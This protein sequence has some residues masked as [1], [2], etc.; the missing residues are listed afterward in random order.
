MTTGGDIAGIEVLRRGAENGTDAPPLLFLHGAF[1]GAWCWDEH[2]MP[3][4][5]DR[6]YDTMAFSFRGHGRS[7]GHAVL[8]GL[9]IDDYVTDLRR[10]VARFRR[11]PVLVGHS[12]GGYVAM[13][14]LQQGGEAAGLVLMASVP[15][16]GLWGPCAWLWMTR[17]VLLW[18]IGALQAVGNHGATVDMAN[19]ALFNGPNGRDLARRYVPRMGNESLRACY[20]MYAPTV[21]GSALNLGVPSLVMGAGLDS[22]IPPL[23]VRETAQSLGTEARMFDGMGH[24]MMLDG[25]WARV[26]TAID[27]WLPG[28]TA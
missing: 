28:G 22:L 3:W 8:H 12:M 26:A 19:A 1:A 4:F 24:G 15:P 6:G 16:S 14:Y 13:R 9:G 21:P 27:D 7:T 17:P 11:P 2:F 20:D 10:V 25:G 5:A 23:S 18:Q